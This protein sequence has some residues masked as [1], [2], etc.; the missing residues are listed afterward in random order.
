VIIEEHQMLQQGKGRANRPGEPEQEKSNM[1]D[2]LEQRTRCLQ[3]C[4]FVAP[5]RQG[6]LALPWKDR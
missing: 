6:R 4:S 1:R 2:S 5:A 3:T